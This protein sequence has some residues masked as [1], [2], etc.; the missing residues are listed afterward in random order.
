MSGNNDVA[1]VAE[2]LNAAVLNSGEYKNYMA[3]REK[4]SLD[5]ALAEKLKQFQEKKM[6]YNARLAEDGTEDMSAEDEL[7]KMFFD[8][9]LNGDARDFFEAEKMFFSLM[10]ETQDKMCEGLE[11]LI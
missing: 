9:S 11:I 6:E 10:T 8:L 5:T 1:R 2:A 4:I 7:S 3:A